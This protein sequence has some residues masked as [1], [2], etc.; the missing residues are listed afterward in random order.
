MTALGDQEELAKE[1]GQEWPVRQEENT[2][3]L[4]VLEAKCKLFKEI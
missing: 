4:G 2:V 1:C 3:E